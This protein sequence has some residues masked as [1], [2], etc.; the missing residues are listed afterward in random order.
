VKTRRRLWVQAHPGVYDTWILIGIGVGVIVGLATGT[1]FASACLGFV[2]GNC[3][4]GALRYI[5]SLPSLSFY[6]RN[7]AW[8]G[9]LLTPSPS[10]WQSEGHDPRSIDPRSE[11]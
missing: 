3:V 8:I 5:N 1:V 2:F 10:E 6:Q 4:T 7:R 11:K 9:S